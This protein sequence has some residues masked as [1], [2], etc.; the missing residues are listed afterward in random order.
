MNINVN[1]VTLERYQDFVLS[2][3][4]KY[5]DSLNNKFLFLAKCYQLVVNIN[6]A[7]VFPISSGYFQKGPE[8]SISIC[9]KDP[10]EYV[11]FIIAHEFAHL[12]FDKVDDVLLVSGRA[13]DESTYYSAIQRAD[14]E[15][16]TYGLALEEA[17]ADALAKWIVSDMGFENSS[18]RP[19]RRL[20][21]SKEG[22]ELVRKLSR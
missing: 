13:N 20:D 18:H 4:Q 11:A 19:L 5:L 21:G 16:N 15:G 1:D 12:L 3:Y 2:I 10:D 9:P 6:L 7:E 17:C 14:D 8:I 22:A